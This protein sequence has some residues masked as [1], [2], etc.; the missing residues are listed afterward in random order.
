MAETPQNAAAPVKTAAIAAL[1]VV[2]FAMLIADGSAHALAVNQKWLELSGLN[3]SASLG[4]GWLSVLDPDSRARLRED[5]LRVAAGGGLATADYQLGG[6]TLGRWT[7]WWVSRHELDGMPLLAIAIADVHEDH[8][9]Q[10]NLYHLATHDSLTGLINRSHF[11]ESADQALRRNERHGRRVGVVFVDL[12]GFKRVNDVG[13]HSLGD[14]VLY[15]IGARLRHAVRNADM[16]ARIGGDEFAVLCEDLT[17]VEQ[18]EVVARRISVALGESVELDGE[19]WSVAASVGAAVD[20]GPPDTAEDLLDRADRAMYAMKSTRRESI[21]TVSL[22]PEPAAPAPSSGLAAVVT[23]KRRAPVYD[24]RAGDRGPDR[25]GDRALAGDRARDR[26]GD[27]P[28]DRA[29]AARRCTDDPVAAARQHLVTDMLAL[30]DSLDAIRDHLGRLASGD[31]GVI[32][33]C[34]K[35]DDNRRD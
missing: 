6:E 31:A 33:V 14:R 15:A 28:P 11:V 3:K 23:E 7:R 34:E 19:R 30:R 24:R 1:E 18:A 22:R 20:H 2:P 5:A 13:G 35:L 4:F 25:A 27:R 26:A 12:D 9:K 21:P 17:A 29:G 10:A 32:D 8:T 16:V